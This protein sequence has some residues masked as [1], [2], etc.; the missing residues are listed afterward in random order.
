M[1]LTRSVSLRMRLKKKTNQSRFWSLAS[2]R[3]NSQKIK[4]RIQRQRQVRI[5]AEYVVLANSRLP[6]ENLKLVA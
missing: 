6:E 3:C 5:T 4:T 1:R 2:T